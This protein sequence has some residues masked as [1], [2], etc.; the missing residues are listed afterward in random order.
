MESKYTL[1]I[2]P[3]A[4]IDMENIFKYIAVNLNNSTAANDLIDEFQRNLL[5]V[6]DNPQMC[7][8][9]DN[10]FLKDKAIR[11]LVIRNYIIFYRANRVKQ[12]VQVVRVLYGRVNY[13]DLLDE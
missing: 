3:R 12:E 7:P 11:K 5:L 9:V 2:Y 6:C 10:M 8:V 1:N 13:F 4:Q